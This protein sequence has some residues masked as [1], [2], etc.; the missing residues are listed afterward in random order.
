MADRSYSKDQQVIVEKILQH[1]SHEYY[2]ILDISSNA[3]DIEI[4]K[5]YRKISLKVHPDKNSHPKAADCF[6]IV[7]KAF[8]VLGD[9][10]KRTIYDQTGAD[11]DQRGGGFPS[12]SSNGGASP[13]GGSPFGGSPFGGPFGN[14]Q[15]AGGGGGPQF[16]FDNDLFDILFGNT[17]GTT[18]SFGGAGPGQTYTFTS[19]GTPFGFGGVPRQRRSRQ[20]T[21]Q[22]QQQQTPPQQPE[23][24]FN[25]IKQLLP[26]FA[27]LIVPIISNLFADTSSNIPF[28]LQKTG[29]FTVER[30]SSRFHVPYY[31]KQSSAPTL[32]EKN[33]KKLDKEAEHYYVGVLKN[34]CNREQNFKDEQINDAYGWFFH[35][36]EK[37]D[38]ANAIRLPS[39]EKLGHLGLL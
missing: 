21:R 19:G 29:A 23:D 9:T 24:L 33:E 4:K 31:I 11:P 20:Q 12:S 16:Q 15:T 37:L 7:N 36:Q 25:T 10:Q 35:N 27:V 30:T 2:K 34:Q 39:C 3:T 6:K 28:Q 5:S 13:F 14:F 8:E 17:Q 38:E 1:K 26:L 32:N 18:F 22:Q